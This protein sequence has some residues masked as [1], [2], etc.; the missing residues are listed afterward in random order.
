MKLKVQIIRKRKTQTVLIFM[1]EMRMV[2][3]GL[4]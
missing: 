2:M 4:Y 1:S 3:S